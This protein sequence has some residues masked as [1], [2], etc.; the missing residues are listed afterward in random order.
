MS[1]AT[2]RARVATEDPADVL[3]PYDLMGAPELAA[4][5]L[6]EHAI[7]VARIAL[8]AQ[9][10]ELLDPD[11]PTQREPQPGGLLTT[12]FFARSYDLAVV[13]RRYRAAVADA[14]AGLDASP[15]QRDPACRPD[16]DL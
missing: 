7:D 11:A 1:A 8:L 12:A 5:A 10:V 16:D 13:I 15:D 2:P 3:S 6:L 14:A 9:H 4:L